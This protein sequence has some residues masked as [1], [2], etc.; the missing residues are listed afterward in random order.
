[1]CSSD[2]LLLACQVF[3]VMAGGWISDRLG[4]VRANLLFNAIALATLLPAWNCFER[5]TLEGLFWAQ[6]LLSLPVAALFGMQGAL[7]AEMCPAGARCT[8][9]GI[10]YS[11]AVAAFAGTVPAM[12][13]W[14]VGRMGWHGAPLAYLVV[15]VL[16]SLITLAMLRGNAPASLGDRDAGRT[17]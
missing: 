11:L 12:F 2:L 6:V 5:G 7:V 10:S 13:T 17:A 15:T 14:M 3:I 4:R 8:V 9:Y 1:M 16:A